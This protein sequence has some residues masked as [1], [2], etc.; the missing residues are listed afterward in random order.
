MIVEFAG[1]PGAG[2]TT[3][4]SAVADALREQGNRVREP[5]ERLT[6]EVST[7]RR[8]LTKAG[9]AGR[10]FFSDPG[11]AGTTAGVLRESGQTKSRMHIKNIFN[12]LFVRGVYRAATGEVSTVLDQGLLQGLWSIAYYSRDRPDPS[13]EWFS[14]LSTVTQPVCIVL[15]EASEDI[16]R[17]RLVARET[18]EGHPSELETYEGTAAAYDAYDTVRTTAKRLEDSYEN[19]SVMTVTNETTE[20]VAAAVERIATASDGRGG[21]A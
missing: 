21:V 12:M 7:P 2:K 14:F 13:P 20:D 8:I 1:V 5:T 16:V 18:G 6:F 15:V 3:V 4:A 17:D 10:A 9:I 11:Y 19:V